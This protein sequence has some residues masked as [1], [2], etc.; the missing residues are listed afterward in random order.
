MGTRMH[1]SSSQ[2]SFFGNL[3]HTGNMARAAAATCLAS[4]PCR[5]QIAAVCTPYMI[6]WLLACVYMYVGGYSCTVQGDT[7]L[8]SAR[9]LCCC[10]VSCRRGATCWK[11]GVYHIG[12]HAHSLSHFALTP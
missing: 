12:V 2:R 9:L 4:Q 8:C 3:T 6:S 7:G 5:I 1:L 10:I 11:S